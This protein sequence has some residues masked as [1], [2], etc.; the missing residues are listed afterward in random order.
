MVQLNPLPKPVIYTKELNQAILLYQEQ[1]TNWHFPNVSLYLNVYGKH[2]RNLLRYDENEWEFKP[3]SYILV[4]Q[5]LGQAEEQYN[6]QMS[7]LLL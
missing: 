4:F 3:D 7:N 1:Q 5:E 2:K 6:T